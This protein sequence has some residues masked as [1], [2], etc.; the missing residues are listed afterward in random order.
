MAPL[1]FTSSSL[2]NFL[3]PVTRLTSSSNLQ[4]K[5][6]TQQPPLRNFTTSQTM[7]S[8]TSFM[9]AVKGRR[10]HYQL[11]KEA[12]ISDDKLEQLVNDTVLHTPSSF[13]NQSARLVVLLKGEHDKFWEMVKSV[14]KPQIPAEQFEGTAKKL[15]GFKAA[16][17]TI[18]FFEDPEPIQRLQ[19]AFALYADKFPQW[20]EHTSAMH[21]Y[22]LWAGLESEGFGANL[23]HYN[24]VVDQAAQNEWKIPQEW[25]LKAQLVFGGKV[26]QPGDKSFE[27]L[28]K[29]VFFHGK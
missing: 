5:S 8:S 18:L 27:P 25:S 21:Q 2:H 29:R 20:S 28:E 1:R 14:L 17:G 15:D 6:T 10:S 11:N 16:Y 23:Q 4:I 24:P 3:R 7:A 26:G 12:P 13:N 22:V 9:D 19:K